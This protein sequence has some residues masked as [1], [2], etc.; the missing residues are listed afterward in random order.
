MR[1]FRGKLEKAM[2]TGHMVKHED[3]NGEIPSVLKMIP[4]GPRVLIK[5]AQFPIQ[6]KSNMIQD[7]H[8]S[9]KKAYSSLL[10]QWL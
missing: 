5:A 6:R 1:T 9:T 4:G 10:F 2:I 7:Q 8:T 3:L